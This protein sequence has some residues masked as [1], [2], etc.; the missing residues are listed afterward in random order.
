MK[1]RS[2]RPLFAALAVL[3]GGCALPLDLLGEDEVVQ[4]Q[5]QSLGQ[6][7]LADDRIEDKHPAVDP[8]LTIDEVFDGCTV[9]LNKSGAVTKLDVVPFDASDQ[10]I[11]A[12]L[13]PTYTSA[14]AALGSRTILPSMEVVNAAL[15]PFDDGLYA[16]V[17]LGAEDASQGSPIAKR[18]LLTDLLTELLAHA[19]SGTA[20]EQPLAREAAGTIGAALQLGADN[21]PVR[22]LRKQ[23][24]SSTPSTPI[25]SRHAP[26]GSIRGAPR[27]R[28]S[29]GRTDSCSRRRRRSA[30]SPRPPSSS[31]PTR[32]S[33]PATRRSS[34]S[35]PG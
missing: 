3:A 4:L 6:N 35:M 25:P 5:S 32:R 26:L 19:T 22:S 28:P 17:E 29:S 14:A 27:C 9:T 31:T 11:G 24:P 2:G 7:E 1:L 20:A 34:I 8:T 16:A 18:A 12:T 33:Q 13:F 30:L 10:A 21:H 15:K 23:R